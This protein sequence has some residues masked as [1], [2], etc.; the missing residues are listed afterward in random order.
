MANEAWTALV[1]GMAGLALDDEHAQL[2]DELQLVLQLM[3]DVALCARDSMVARVSTPDVMAEVIID[4][5]STLAR[6]SI[7]PSLVVSGSEITEAL[8]R[9]RAAGYPLWGN[10]PWTMPYLKAV[11][12]VV[13]FFQTY[14]PEAHPRLDPP[15]DHYLE[16]LLHGARRAIPSHRDWAWIS[17]MG[18]GFSKDRRIELLVCRA[19][20]DDEGNPIPLVTVNIPQMHCIRDCWSAE[21]EAAWECATAAGIDTSI[22]GL[23]TAKDAIAYMR[24]YLEAVCPGAPLQAS[25]RHS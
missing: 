12:T 25:L 24:A 3:R 5:F 11:K 4:Q 10:Y 23:P 20:K 2:E 9:A 14:L 16:R 1:D 6:L 7:I 17:F 21:Q 19:D 15:M 18:R 22:V 8:D 13:V